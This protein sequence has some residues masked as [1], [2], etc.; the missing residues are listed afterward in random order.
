MAEEL[1]GSDDGRVVFA[2]ERPDFE[3]LP[4]LTDFCE[5]ACFGET[6][7]RFA[8]VFIEERLGRCRAFAEERL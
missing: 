4:G 6:I 3:P 7:V 2:T 8:G 1:R 5:L